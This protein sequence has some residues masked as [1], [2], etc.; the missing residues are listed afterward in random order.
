[1]LEAANKTEDHLNRMRA[2]EAE[3]QGDKKTQK[4]FQLM[5]DY[6]D[7]FF[8]GERYTM[9]MYYKC[10]AHKTW[11]NLGGC[12]AVIRADCWTQLLTLMEKAERGGGRGGTA[13]AGLATPR[14]TARASR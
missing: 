4:A 2:F 13:T 3:A 10:Q 5:A 8:T 14:P 11:D 6:S 7:Q 1:M 9:N 12:K